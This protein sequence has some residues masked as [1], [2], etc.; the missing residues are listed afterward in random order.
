MW[1]Y[2]KAHQALKK[3]DLMLSATSAVIIAGGLAG[4]AVFL[5]AVALGA[6]GI[7]LGV[8]TKKKII[9]EKSS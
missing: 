7:V 9:P 2:K 5:S 6:C 4:T 1:Y 3:R 8:I